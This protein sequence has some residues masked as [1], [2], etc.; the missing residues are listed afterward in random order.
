MR[1]ISRTHPH[2]SETRSTCLKP[3]NSINQLPMAGNTIAVDNR[4]EIRHLHEVS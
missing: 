3:S 2:G 4:M 1:L